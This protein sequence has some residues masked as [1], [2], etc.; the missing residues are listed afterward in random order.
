MRLLLVS[1]LHYTLRAVRLGGRSCADFD[2]VVMAGDQLDIRSTVPLDAQ[3]VVDAAAT[4]SCCRPPGGSSSAPATTISPVRTRNGERA[5]RCGSSEARR[6]GVPTDGDAVLRRR[7]AHHDLPVVGRPARARRRRRP[8]RRATRRSRPARWIWVYHWPPL[9]SPTCLDRQAAPTATTSSAAWIDEHRPDVVLSGHVH[10]PP[11]KPDGGWADRIGP[12]W[13]FNAGRQIGATPTCIEI[14][15]D[16][17]LATWTS[18]M[19]SEEID[20]TAATRRRGR[21]SD[22]GQSARSGPGRD[23]SRRRRRPQLG[24]RSASG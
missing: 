5:A 8:A 6:R 10:E 12:T 13:V 3:I 1:D 23:V 19:G 16:A 15:F 7:H 20:L 4:S 2:L 17:Q 14:D 22:A 18:L 24:L 9:G 21:S 11:F